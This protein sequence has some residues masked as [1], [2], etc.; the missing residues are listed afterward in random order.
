VAFTEELSAF[1]DTADFAV[2]ATYRAG[3]TGPLVTKSVIFDRAYLE[4][5]GISGSEP[6]ALGIATDFAT[7]D[8]SD[9]LA[10]GGTTY[11]IS[12]VE[13]QDDGGTVLIRL[14]T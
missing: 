12:T 7:A 1:F 11:R 13:P 9:T 10:I 5:L 4:T 8:A 14:S 3:G 2:E 6:V